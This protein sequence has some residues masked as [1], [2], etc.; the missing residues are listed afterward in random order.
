MFARR[1]HAI[2]RMQRQIENDQQEKKKQTE[3]MWRGVKDRSSHHAQLRRRSEDLTN[4]LLEA[5]L[6]IDMLMAT[7]IVI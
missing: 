4:A 6:I 1:D 2:A 5:G 7:R 3:M